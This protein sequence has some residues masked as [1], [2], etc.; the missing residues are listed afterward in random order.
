MKKEDFTDRLIRRFFG[1]MGPFDEYRQQVIYRAA[2]RALV[3]IVYSIFV[4]SV[5]AF[6]RALYKSRA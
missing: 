2:A 4:L 1:V 3:R 5:S 6:Y